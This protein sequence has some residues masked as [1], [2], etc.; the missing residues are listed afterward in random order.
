MGVAVVRPP[1]AGEAV[2][3]STVDEFLTRLARHGL[4]RSAVRPAFGMA[5]LGSGITYH[6]PTADEPVKVSIVDR[7]SLSGSL[8]PVP[9]EHPRAISFT[10][11][12]VPSSNAMYSCPSVI[13]STIVETLFSTA[14]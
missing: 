4:A 10:L 14:K 2:S 1:M 5:E 9:R 11:S 13:S 7:A 3:S 6:Q 12:H 8:V